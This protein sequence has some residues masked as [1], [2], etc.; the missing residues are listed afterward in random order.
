MYFWNV[1]PIV[2]YFKHVFSVYFGFSTDLCLYW[3]V[4]Y[5]HIPKIKHV[6]SFGP[7][8]FYSQRVE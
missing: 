2:F 6:A 5:I 3:C 4:T 7:G 1:W 8:C